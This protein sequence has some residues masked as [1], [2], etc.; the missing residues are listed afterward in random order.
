MFN[1]LEMSDFKSGGEGCIHTTYLWFYGDFGDGVW[2]DGLCTSLRS[3]W[4]RGIDWVL[5]DLY[6]LIIIMFNIFHWKAVSGGERKGN[7]TFYQ[8]VRD[9]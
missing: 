3:A 8:E 9:V 1:I 5:M 4:R 6:H 7:V 2:G